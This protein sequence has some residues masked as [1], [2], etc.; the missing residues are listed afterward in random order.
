MNKRVTGKLNAK[1]QLI[2]PM[3]YIA[4]VHCV[5]II[6]KLTRSTDTIVFQSEILSSSLLHC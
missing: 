4:S 6:V 2:R 5:S 3:R 1:C